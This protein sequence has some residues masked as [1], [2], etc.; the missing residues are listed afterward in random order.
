MEHIR[1]ILCTLLFSFQLSENNLKAHQKNKHEYDI[2][3]SN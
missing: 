3:E 2:F 1:R